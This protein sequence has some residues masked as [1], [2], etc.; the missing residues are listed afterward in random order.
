MNEL[1]TTL[2]KDFSESQLQFCKFISANDAGLTGGHQCGPYIPKNSYSLLFDEP[3][4][5][6]TNSERTVS[7]TWQNGITTES[8]CKYYGCGTRNEYRITAF[9]RGFPY[10][11]NEFVGALL[12]LLKFDSYTYK[13]YVLNTDDEIEYFFSS[14]GITP[15][16]TNK[17]IS[18]SLTVN[19][20]IDIYIQDLAEDFPSTLELAT[21]SRDLYYSTNPNLLNSHPDTELLA[22]LDMEY[23]LF[24]ALEN[25]RYNDY[26]T[27][28]FANLDELISCSNTILNRR[29]SRAGKSL[30]HHLAY[31]F[32]QNNI[33]F[34][35]QIK[36]EGNKKPDF[37]FP[38]ERAYH[39]INYNLEKL[40]YLAS[41]TTC[42]DRWRQILNEADKISTK[43]L[44]TLQQGISSNQLNEMYSSNVIL[45]VPRPYIKT[46]PPE[47]QNR[48]LSLQDFINI[49]KSKADL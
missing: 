17:L 35:A 43:Y 45:V 15:T 12:I 14:I 41:K 7:I 8:K 49:V 29:K 23:E 39:S 9:G 6:G 44:F 26:I 16:E 10:F 13:G 30:E 2:L 5:R 11:K 47:Y 42:K 20:V 25:N 22:W 31:I 40:T 3:Q 27:K 18:S 38:S 48:I 4:L 32:S 24:K 28:P 34:G 37:I 33:E 21:K 19:G 36:T 46:F 1:L